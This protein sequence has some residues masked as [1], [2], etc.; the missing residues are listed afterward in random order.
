MRKL[1]LKVDELRVEAFVTTIAREPV[2]G[3][4]RGFYLTYDVSACSPWSCNTMPD[5][6]MATCPE[7]PT[8]DGRPTCRMTC[9][10][11]GCTAQEVD[12]TL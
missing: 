5:C 7:G 10:G 8:N 9:E 2:R 6:S 11:P 4:I 12:E 3:T 1:N